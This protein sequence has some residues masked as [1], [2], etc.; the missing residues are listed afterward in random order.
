MLWQS[1][2][3]NP[4]PLGLIAFGLTTSLLNLK[5]AQLID[6]SNSL[7]MIF[8][9]GIFVGGLAQVIAGILEFIKGNTFEFTAFISFGFFWIT[10]VFINVFAVLGWSP[11]V[12]HASVAAYLMFWGIFSAGMLVHTFKKNL[13]LV[14]L[15][16]LLVIQF[17]LLA[18]AELLE[19]KGHTGTASILTR[20]A[21][22][23]GLIAGLI[24]IYTSIAE[25]NDWPVFS[26]PNVLEN[27][28]L[29]KRHSIEIFSVLK[30]SI[31]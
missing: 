7:S 5:N 23:E 9:M 22:F 25:L 31:T 17:S 19:F 4:A 27:I 29:L 3:A 11:V 20:V 18:L 14:M 12:D 6:T 30:N 16:I 26:I 15:F 13:M 2:L 10:F 21:G 8:A 1:S 24:A 28:R